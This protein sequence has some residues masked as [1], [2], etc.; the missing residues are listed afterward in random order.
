MIFNYYKKWLFTCTGSHDDDYHLFSQ[1][2]KTIINT[3]RE[4]TEDYDNESRYTE[5]EDPL[6][7]PP[8]GSEKRGHLIRLTG[9]NP[10][11]E[12]DENFDKFEALKGRKLRI[13][14]EP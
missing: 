5:H 1:I 6:E 11:I 7:N 8:P 3:L 4:F 14:L 9:G 10:A 12:F 13:F 2:E